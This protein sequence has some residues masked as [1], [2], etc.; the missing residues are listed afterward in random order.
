[1]QDELKEYNA[2][3]KNKFTMS[4]TIISSDRHQS[5]PQLVHF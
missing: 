2:I 1:M 5:V 3:K 4:M